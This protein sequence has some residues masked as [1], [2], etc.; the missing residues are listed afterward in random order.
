M[1]Q[2]LNELG[3]GDQRADC[4]SG[5][6][7]ELYNNNLGRDHRQ[8]YRYIITHMKTYTCVLKAMFR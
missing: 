1:V 2:Q 8:L 3:E 5:H 6:T 4:H 7:E